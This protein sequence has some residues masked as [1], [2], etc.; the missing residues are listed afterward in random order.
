MARLMTK[1]EVAM[2]LGVAPSTIRLWARTGR[3]PEIHI[4]PKV[5]RF[6]LADVLEALRK[7]DNPSVDPKS[8]GS[9]I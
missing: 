3:I 5:R 4:T 2:E 1:E 7:P 9:R 8:G 6:D